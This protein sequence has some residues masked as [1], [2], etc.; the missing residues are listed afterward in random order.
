VRDNLIPRPLDNLRQAL[1]LLASPLIWLFSSLGVF[2]KGA[3][4]PSEFSDLSVNI[5]VP[6]TTAFSIWGPI[7]IG[8]LAYGIVQLLPANRARA[9]YRDSGWWIAAGLWGIASWGLITAYVPDSY[10]ELLASLI[11]IPAMICLVVAMTK[12]W[13]GRNVLSSLEKWL[14]LTPVSFIAGWC[15]LAVFVG[16][17]GLIWSAA[18]P[19]GWHITGTALSVLGIALWW[20]IY[21]LRQQAMNKAYAIPIIWGL[22]FLA[23]RH[24]NDGENLWIG[25]AAAIGILSVI[26]A[27][28][29]RGK[30]QKIN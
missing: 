8:I 19:L 25:G 14:V 29:V 30:A 4:S 2:I 27:S 7:F 5:L 9:I 22:G 6:Q 16:L 1:I 28:C 21:I 26:L 10:V 20:A 15:S 23:L 12:L 24:F 17:N 13:R 11:F 3:R 18:Q